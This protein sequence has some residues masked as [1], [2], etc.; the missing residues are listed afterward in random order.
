VN[1]FYDIHLHRGKKEKTKKTKPG[2]L[3]EFIYHACRQE[4]LLGAHEGSFLNKKR[5]RSM[6][7]QSYKIMS[8]DPPRR[9][10]STIPHISKWAKGKQKVRWIHILY[11][12]T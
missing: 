9:A 5:H 7:I 2:G 1:L 8:L 6:S 3:I 10:M 4:E 11:V 12:G